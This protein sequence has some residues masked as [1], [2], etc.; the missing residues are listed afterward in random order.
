MAARG[1]S[2]RS[3]PVVFVVLSKGLWF[4]AWDRDEIDPTG[5]FR[6]R[7][8]SGPGKKPGNRVSRAR[9]SRDKTPPSPARKP[10]FASREVHPVQDRAQK[11]ARVLVWAAVN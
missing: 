9:S 5:P 1:K 7:D 6:C 4:A 8:S 10:G 11:C 3:K 2:R